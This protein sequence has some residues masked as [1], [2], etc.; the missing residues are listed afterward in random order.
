MVYSEV[1]NFS[2]PNPVLLAQ[3]NQQNKSVS[4][5]F[6]FMQNVTSVASMSILP[7]SYLQA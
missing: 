2:D 4:A 6:L 5:V 7:F 1:P 3:A